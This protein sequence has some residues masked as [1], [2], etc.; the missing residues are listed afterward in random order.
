MGDGWG[1]RVP[2]NGCAYFLMAV[3]FTVNLLAQSATATVNSGGTVDVARYALWYIPF[4]IPLVL[5]CLE[6]YGPFKRPE[7]VIL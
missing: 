6:A 4:F 2:R 5:V 3:L 7:T 1:A